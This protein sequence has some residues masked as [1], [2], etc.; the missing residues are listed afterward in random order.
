MIYELLLA[1]TCN[2]ALPPAHGSYDRTTVNYNDVVELTCMWTGTVNK[3]RS[4]RCIY[5]NG[6]TRFGGDDITYCPGSV[7]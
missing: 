4:A 7:S 2:T 1:R 6:I 3:T 5:D